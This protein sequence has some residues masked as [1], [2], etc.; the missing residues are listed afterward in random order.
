[1]VPSNLRQRWRR[2][3]RDM[4]TKTT[5][6]TMEALVEDRRRFQ[7]IGDNNRGGSGLTTGPVYWQQQRSVEFPCYWVANS[8]TVSSLSIRCLD[9]IFFSSD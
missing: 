3:W 1:M 6:T 2:W 8:N 9:L 7:G 5:I 4:G